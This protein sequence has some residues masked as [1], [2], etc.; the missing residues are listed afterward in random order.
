MPYTPI[1]VMA[2]IYSKPASIFANVRVAS[3]GITAH[4][5]KAGAIANTGAITNK[6][7][8]DFAGKITSFSISFKPSA[9]GCNKPNGPTRFGPI[10]T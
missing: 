8:F 5:A 4:A 2:K 7:I 6:Y 1:E 10:R 9:I 3:K